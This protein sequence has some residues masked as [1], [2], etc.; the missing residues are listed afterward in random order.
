MGGA[1]YPLSYNI[2]DRIKEH[3]D[4]KERIEIQEKLDMEGTKGLEHALDILDPGGPE[5]TPHRAM[6]TDAIAQVF[7]EI[8]PPLDSHIAFLN[9]ISKRSDDF[10]PIFTLNYDP[11]IELAA[12]NKKLFMVDGFSGFYEAF[13]NQ[14]NFDRVPS[15]YNNI[16]KGRILR[17]LKGILHLYKLHGSVG[18]FSFEDRIVRLNISY[19]KRD[20]WQRLMIPP[21][22]RKAAET[23][24]QPYSSLWTRFRAWLIFG[25][26]PLNRLVCIGY[27]MRDQ[28]VN[29]V[30][31]NA[32]A[33]SDFTLLI[34]AKKIDDVSFRTWG[35][36]GNTIIVT[37]SRCSLYG[38]EGP[39]HTSGWD[40]RTICGEV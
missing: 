4:E 25:P 1:G 17:G 19:E 11:L 12:D 21:Q 6:V 8:T 40:F 13:F 18:W 9:S 24:T 34:F 3:I 10:I 14:N 36:R 27:G 28:H 15:L 33:R 32:T 22:Y 23:I 35:G 7:S 31:D 20:H 26:R 5:P 29:D 38:Q 30:L 2:W 16:P 39:G 37:E